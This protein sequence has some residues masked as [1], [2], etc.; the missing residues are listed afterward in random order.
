M[1][2]SI[3]IVTN[4]VNAKQYVGITN[5]LSRRWK[6]QRASIIATL[7][8]KKAIKNAQKEMV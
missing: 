1:R 3:Y 4:I 7:A 5:D 2:Y 8:I 6:E